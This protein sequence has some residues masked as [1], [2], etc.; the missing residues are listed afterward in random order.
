MNQNDTREHRTVHSHSNKVER[1]SDFLIKGLPR[2]PLLPEYLPNSPATLPSIQGRCRSSLLL[3]EQ[4]RG[5]IVAGLG[6]DLHGLV[7]QGS[8]AHLAVHELVLVEQAQLHL[9]LHPHGLWD[10]DTP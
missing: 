5:W 8:L 1:A 4:T 9:R 7:V 6:H 10:A 2:N 3:M